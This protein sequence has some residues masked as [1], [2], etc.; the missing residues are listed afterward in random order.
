M[1]LEKPT[2][3]GRIVV[4]GYFGDQR[5][6]GFTVETSLDGKAWDMVADWRDNKEPSTPAGIHLPL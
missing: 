3:I 5:Y 2:T 1:D 6:Y 4:V